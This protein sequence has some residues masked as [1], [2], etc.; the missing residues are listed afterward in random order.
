MYGPSF[1]DNV[2]R[3]SVYLRVKRSELIPIMTMFDAP[4]PTQSVGERVSTTVPTQSL[5]MMNSP[6]VRQQAEKLAQRIRPAQDAPPSAAV[7]AA[8]R[9]ALGHSPSEAERTRMTAFI[10][11]Q[12]QAIGGDAGAARDRALVEFCHAL[13]CLNEFVYID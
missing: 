11:Q 12:A 6:F 5:T 4:E 3:R 7:D 8:Y 2:P 13:I 1:L 10:D 9:I